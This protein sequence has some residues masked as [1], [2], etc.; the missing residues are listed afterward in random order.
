MNRL[1]NILRELLYVIILLPSTFLHELAHASFALLT[2]SKVHSFSLIP[3]FN[4]TG[5]INMG[6]VV[7]IPSFEGAKIFIALAPFFWLFAF[8]YY[9]EYLNLLIFTFNDNINITINISVLLVENNYLNGI[10]LFYLFNAG[11]PSP[12]DYQVARDGVWSITGLIIVTIFFIV[13]IKYLNNLV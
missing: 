5:H 7:S 10:V 1:K 4:G 11:W 12:T 9:A 2:G 8:F 3:K 6:E 13:L